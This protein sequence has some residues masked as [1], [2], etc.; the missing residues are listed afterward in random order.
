VPL[1]GEVERQARSELAGYYAHIEATDR[2]I[3]KF[4]SEV[5]LARTNVVFTSVHGDM[6]GSH[7]L[8]RKAWPHEES[9]RVPLL[10]RQPGTAAGRSDEP[11]SLVDLP[12]LAVAWA[13]GRA[14]NCRRDS[15][16]ISMPAATTIPHQCPYAW[17][18]FRSPRRKLVLRSEPDGRES[19]WLYFD[20]ERDPDEHYNL[21]ADPARAKE[22]AELVALL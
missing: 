22:I 7:G 12:H 6:H 15:A 2:A 20:L 18:G 13:E 10:I 4:L 5:D 21:A 16:A 9:V 14:W 19:P 3:G 1:G 8:F 17:R 11:L